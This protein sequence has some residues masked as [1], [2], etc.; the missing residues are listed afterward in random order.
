ME[1][2][3]ADLA[4]GCRRRSAQWAPRPRPACIVHG[5]FGYAP[6]IHK[7]TPTTAV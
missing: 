3:P 6:L 5:V 7:G 4:L 2:S 1:T